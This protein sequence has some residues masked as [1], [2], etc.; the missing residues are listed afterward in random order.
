[1]TGAENAAPGKN[2]RMEH[3]ALR[4]GSFPA[5]KRD[6]GVY[7]HIPFCVHKCAY[8]DFPS[9]AGREDY[10]AAYTD[11]LCREI[12]A[13]APRDARADTVYIGGGTPSVLPAALMERVIG[14]L[15][16][17]MDIAPDAEMSCEMNPG[18][19]TE[20]FAACMR[21]GGFGRVSMGMQAAQNRLLRALDR[22]HTAADVAAST[23]ILRRVGFENLNLDLMLGLPGQTVRDVEESLDFALSLPLTPSHMSCYGLIVE[24]ETRLAAWLDEGKMTLPDGEAERDMYETCRERLAQE[25]IFQ[26]EI[27]NFA[28]PGYACRHN[29]N[30]WRRREYIGFGC[31]ACGMMDN[32]RRTNPRRL[33]DY[34]RGAPPETESISPGDARFESVMLGLRL[35]EGISAADFQAM[36]GVSLEEAFG[37]KW[38]KP[39]REGL[40]TWDGEYL[41]LTRRGMDVQNRVL[42]DL[43]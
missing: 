39:V 5:G 34:L 16:A 24:P 9:W 3:G 6:V 23:D 14:T 40:L 25:G 35:T 1:M 15:R 22:V 38:K 12:G 43:M 27:S 32:V 42:V 33:S 19:V 31:G 8:C 13:R 21:Q 4:T 17:H 29:V 11:A 30:V 7:I 41:K 26:Y 36:H 18:T 37:K 10:M 2:G 28:R 20:D